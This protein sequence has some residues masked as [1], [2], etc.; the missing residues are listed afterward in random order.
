MNMP[1]FT[2]Q[3]SL[4]RSNNRYCSFGQQGELQKTAVIPQLPNKN[5]PGKV[6]CVMD[7]RD[8]HPDWSAAKCAARC[9]DP[10]GIKGSGSGPTRPADANAVCWA[11]YFAC[12]AVGLA[13]FRPDLWASCLF[14]GPCSCE[15]VRDNCFFH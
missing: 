3:A 2:A 10:G 13:A 14:G 11:G 4:Y 1:E 12:S 9:R 15:E 8:Q 5:A 6:G 7:C